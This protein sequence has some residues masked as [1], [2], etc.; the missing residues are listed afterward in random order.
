M[1]DCRDAEITYNV[2]IQIKVKFRQF[3]LISDQGQMLFVIFL[4]MEKT[5]IRS[6]SDQPPESELRSRED[7]DQKIDLIS[8]GQRS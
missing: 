3:I 7:Q 6:R 1:N 8:F 5:K 4:P 2:I